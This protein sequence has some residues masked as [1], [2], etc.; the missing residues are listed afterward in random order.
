MSEAKIFAMPVYHCEIV[1]YERSQELVALT[2]LRARR[3]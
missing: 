2:S 3:F 1:P